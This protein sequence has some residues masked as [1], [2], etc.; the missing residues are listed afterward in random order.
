MQGV[1]IRSKHKDVA[2]VI[3]TCMA[4][5]MGIGAIPCPFDDFLLVLALDGSMAA[6]LVAF[7]ESLSA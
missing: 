4:A 3:V 1:D 2:S 5:A 6:A 7:M